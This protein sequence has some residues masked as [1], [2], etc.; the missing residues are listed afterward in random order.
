MFVNVCR[1]RHFKHVSAMVSTDTYVPDQGRIPCAGL[2]RGR[3]A[4]DLCHSSSP[5]GDQVINPAIP[6][7]QNV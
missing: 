1:V 2:L 7:W 3:P 4:A 6:R 5:F